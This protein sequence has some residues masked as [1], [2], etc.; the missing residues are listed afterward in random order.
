M[1]HLSIARVL[2]TL[3]AIPTLAEAIVTVDGFELPNP[4]ASR[5]TFSPAIINAQLSGLSAA[6]VYGSFDA[7][8]IGFAAWEKWSSPVFSLEPPQYT[9]NSGVLSA[10]LDQGANGPGLSTTGSNPGL[11][12]V[13]GVDYSGRLTT[14]P[15]EFTI[16]ATSTI[17]L[18]SVTLYIKHSP[19]FIDG[20]A[21]TAFTASLNGLASEPVIKGPNLGNSSDAISLNTTYNMYSYTWNNL[22]IDPNEPFTL[23]FFSG[24]DGTGQGFSIDSVAIAASSVPEP[25]SC[26]LL[27]LSAAAV[28]LRR[29]RRMAADSKC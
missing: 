19:Y 5:G 28:G 26:A 14:G 8:N 16:E 9:G 15:Y 22:S 11:I 6:S 7:P 20:S 10:T 23:D 12:T 27:M 1:H 24:A 3:C 29:S 21:V 2:L 17:F 4:N 18:S 25:S 13:D